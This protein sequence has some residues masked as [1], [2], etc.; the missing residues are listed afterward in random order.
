M[1]WQRKQRW[2]AAAAVVGLLVSCSDRMG[3]TPSRLASVIGRGTLSSPAFHDGG[4]IPVRFTCDGQDVSP[5]IAW[6][7]PSGASP[8]LDYV[9]LVV[10]VDA[11]GG[12]FVHW[13]AYQLSGSGSIPEG[14]P[15]PGNVGTNSFG[16]AAYSGP[17]P[18]GGDAP[19][20]YRFRLYA[21][22]ASHTP[23]PAGDTVD[24]LLGG[25]PSQPPIAEL[26]GTYARS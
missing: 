18:P 6:R 21:L 14:G 16:A 24:E 20:R 15:V 12:G 3:T 13:L 1:N 23:V 5:P 2:L 9:L 7:A 22:F 8:G 19:H 4:A 25:I 26:T 10:D 11:P 17:C